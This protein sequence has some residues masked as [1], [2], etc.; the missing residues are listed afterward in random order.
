MYSGVL[1][2]RSRLVAR[3]LQ[4]SG[5]VYT[6]L[7]AKTP[8]D[9]KMSSVDPNWLKP[10]GIQQRNTG[11]TWL[12]DHLN[13]NELRN[14]AGVLYFADDDNTYDV[15]L[16]EEV[17]YSMDF[18]SF[19]SII[20]VHPSGWIIIVNK[21]EIRWRCIILILCGG[22][23]ASLKTGFQWTFNFKKIYILNLYPRIFLHFTSCCPRENHHQAIKSSKGTEALN[24]E[25][26]P[27]TSK[28]LPNF[29]H[30]VTFPAL[31]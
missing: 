5:L 25:N 4:R 23:L 22:Q 26:V 15:R 2:C 20:C 7:A 28:F 30:S 1:W 14:T 21:T 18:I 8:D 12:R 11:L 16:F 19:H 6:H 9:F 17:L 31:F 10:R 3:L 24:F 29:P 13:T 27:R